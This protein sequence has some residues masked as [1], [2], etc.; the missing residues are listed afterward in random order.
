[1]NVLYAMRMRHVVSGVVVVVLM[2]EIFPCCLYIILLFERK[3]SKTKK[4]E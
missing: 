2:S 4:K 1:M 3:D